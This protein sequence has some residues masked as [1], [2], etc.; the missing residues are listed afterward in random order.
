MPAVELFQ[1]KRQ[2]LYNLADLVRMR[3]TAL[4]T[5]RSLPIG[6]ERNQQRQIAAS[7]GSLVRN[8]DW[9]AEHLSHGPNADPPRLYLESVKISALF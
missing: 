4:R 6:S 8:E 7:L 1:D 9:L 2:A 3:R 5:A